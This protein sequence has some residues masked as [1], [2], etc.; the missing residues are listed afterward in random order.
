M[1]NQADKSLL[2]NVGIFPHRSRGGMISVRRRNYRIHQLETQKILNRILEIKN[3]HPELS[4]YLNR[5]PEFRPNRE[6]S[7]IRMAD[8]RRYHNN[9]LELLEK[10]EL[11][12]KKQF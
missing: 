9:L 1:E 7:E 2:K 11:E 5:I 8:L 6:D 4:K 3:R 10:Y 12:L